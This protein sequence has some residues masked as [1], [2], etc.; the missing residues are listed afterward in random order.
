M[1]GRKKEGEG[2]GERRRRKERTE[3]GKKTRSE[4]ERERE[5]VLAK[6]TWK[7]EDKEEGR[8]ARITPRRVVATPF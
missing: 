3:R 2:G 1:K 6:E 8:R 7:R 4:R 5:S